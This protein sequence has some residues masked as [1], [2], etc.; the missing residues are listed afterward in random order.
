MGQKAEW[1][2]T[3][4]GKNIEWKKRRTGQNVKWKNTEWDKMLNV[5]TPNGTKR[6]MKKRSNG[7]KC[8]MEIWKEKYVLIFF[9]F[10]LLL[11]DYMYNNVEKMVEN[12]ENVRGNVC[13]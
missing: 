5:K 12:V 3:S 13:I 10:L 8:Q 9:G 6:R 1:D 4:N 11:S 2:K 7:T